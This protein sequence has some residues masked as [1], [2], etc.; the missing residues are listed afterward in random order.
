MPGLDW[1]NP[2]PGAH[3]PADPDGVVDVDGRIGVQQQKVGGLAGPNR[4][5][6]RILRSRDDPRGVEGG[7][8]DRD[9]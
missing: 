2:L 6:F 5:V 7:G 4:P 9:S 1:W 8:A 3:H